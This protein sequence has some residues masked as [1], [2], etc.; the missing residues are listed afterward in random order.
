MIPAEKQSSLD[1]IEAN[2]ARLSRFQQEIW[3]YAETA[4]REYRSAR[5]YCEL[6]RRE[7]FTVEEGTGGMPTAFKATWGAG[8]PILGSFAEYDATPENSQQ[9]VPY[10]APR[11]GLHPMAPGHTDPHSALG[12]AALAGI[13]AAK[14]AMEQHR[15]PGTLVLFGE[16]AE[17]VCGSKPVH[18][19]KGYYDGA[20]AYVVFHPNPANTTAWETQFGSY[21][22]ALFSFESVDPESWIDHAALPLRHAHAGARSPGA[23]DAACLM[24]TSTRYMKDSMFPATGNWTLSE[25]MMVGGQCT[26]DNLPP[27]IS[28][29]QYAWRSPGLGLQERIAR[30]LENNAR[31]VAEMTNCQFTLRWITKTRV[32][33]PNL[34]LARVVYRNLETVGPPQL[35]ARAVEFA[36]TIQ[37][38]LGFTPM[39]EPFIDS[40]Q[41]LLPPEEN[42]ANLRR[43]LPPWQHHFAA[44][45]YVEYTWHAPTARL[46]CGRPN[47]K[48]PRPNY[49]YPAWVRNAIGGSPDCIDPMTF[50]AGRT[51]ACSLV[52]LVTNAEELQ[53][54]QAEFSERTGGGV[55][56]RNWVGP[57]LPR[58]FQPPID[59]RWPEYVTTPRGEEWWIPTPAGGDL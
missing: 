18:A 8:R 14:A 43:G 27:A 29:I 51:I 6:L 42:E 10:R 34:A 36:R 9:P 7:G 5:A 31:R 55:G 17:K 1:W 12:V 32:A 4:F 3:E 23:L 57:L 58:D 44:D 21:W 41:R 49:E 15:L 19:A 20:D 54:A 25:F 59:L 47:L 45:D 30:I 16:P 46:Y 13:L 52:D 53:A 40:C 22:S 38:N 48:P 39:N 26:A 2:R 33:L 35:N 37:Q 50:T 11:A 56:G 24:Y 28:Q